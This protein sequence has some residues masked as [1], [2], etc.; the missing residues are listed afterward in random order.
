MLRPAAE[1]Q[2]LKLKIEDILSQNFF[3]SVTELSVKE[4]GK[5]TANFADQTLIKV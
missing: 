5:Q 1:K 3:G 4:I 2:K